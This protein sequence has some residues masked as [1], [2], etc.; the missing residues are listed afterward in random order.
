M[1]LKPNE[2]QTC[3]H[4]PHAQWGP[5][6]HCDAQYLAC[7]AWLLWWP[8]R[9]N[10]WILG[11]QVWHSPT[12]E[13]SAQRNRTNLRVFD[14][15]W[16]HGINQA[17]HAFQQDETMWSK[18]GL[19]SSWATTSRHCCRPIWEGIEVT[20]GSTLDLRQLMEEP[21]SMARGIS[22]SADHCVC[23]ITL[24]RRWHQPASRNSWAK[25][26]SLSW[27]NQIEWIW[28]E[29]HV[30]RR[31]T[32]SALLEGSAAFGRWCK[33]SW[34]TTMRTHSSVKSSSHLNTTSASAAHSKFAWPCKHHVNVRRN[35]TGLW[36]T[37]LLL[38]LV[39]T[40]YSELCCW[41]VVALCVLTNVR[42]SYY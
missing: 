9:I 12:M 24:H 27:W 11:K 31:E 35:L 29:E 8:W 7:N 19:M 26:R 14:L 41:G 16:W 25:T 39:R 3:R 22:W 18:F 30:T 13:P 6:S 2:T 15:W 4:F 32:E 10:P 20:A 40:I 23:L 38:F 17:S 37:F 5:L 33:T 36:H 1:S 21:L 28:N 42:R 34:H